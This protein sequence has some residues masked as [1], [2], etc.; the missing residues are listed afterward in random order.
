MVDGAIVHW[1]DSKAMY[2]DANSWAM[3]KY[4]IEGGDDMTGSSRTDTH[5][6]IHPR[7]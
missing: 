1:I 3:S 7:E 4:V 5:D 2:G 6:I